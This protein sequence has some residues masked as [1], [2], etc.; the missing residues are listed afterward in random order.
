MRTDA[1]PLAERRIVVTRAPEQSREIL[2]LLCAA[3]AEAISL[4]MVRFLE[5]EDT[6]ALDQAIGALDTFDWLVLT[7]ANAVNFFLARCR[8]LGRWPSDRKPRIA[9]VGPATRAAIEEARLQVSFVP[10]VFNGAALAAELGSQLREARVLL[11]R[12]DRADAE[13]PD[14]LT[15]AGADVTQVVAYRTAVPESRDRALLDRI[16]TGGV[17]AVIFFSPSAV[18][19]FAGAVGSEK[20]RQIG[21]RVTLAA[22]GSVTAAAIREAGATASVEGPK[23][24][25][26]ALVLALEQHFAL[27]GARKGSL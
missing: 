19:E 14:A 1:R 3:G 7:S 23:A 13:L 11:P 4:P 5:P 25:P 8:V 2:E 17:D 27:Q 6:S 26:V 12:S 20:F 22:V 18:R 24:T 15:A 16:C 9:A 21:D 10:R